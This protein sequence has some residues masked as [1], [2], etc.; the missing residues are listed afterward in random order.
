M[1]EESTAASHALHQ[2]ASG[3]SDLVGHFQTVTD[4]RS[5]PKAPAR[6]IA[7]PQPANKP[8]D[9]P[10]DKPAVRPAGRPAQPVRSIASVAPREVK[11]ATT[12]R[13]VWQEF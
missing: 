5:V 6:V 3:L 4:G 13:G 12:G 1:V 7:V 9:R 10:A 11:S 2:D 8:A